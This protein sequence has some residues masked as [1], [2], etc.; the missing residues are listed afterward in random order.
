MS[1]KVFVDTNILVYAHDRHTERKRAKAAERILTLWKERCGV[2]STQVLQEFFVNVT[3]KSSSPLSTGAAKR[4]IQN[5]LAWQVV[6][7]DGPAILEA[8]DLQGRFRLSFW[9]ALIVQSALSAGC[10]TIL[11]E[12]L[13]PGQRYESLRVVNPFLLP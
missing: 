5:Y 12:D 11:S 3:R 8:I 7:N 1:D 10:S 6:V 9:D 13:N 4:V 2:L